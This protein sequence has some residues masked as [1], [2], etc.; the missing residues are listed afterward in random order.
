MKKPLTIEQAVTIEPGD[1]V[2]F[3]DGEGGFNPL[4]VSAVRAKDS[5]NDTVIH[6]R[7]FTPL[8]EFSSSAEI[9]DVIITPVNSQISYSHSRIYAEA[10]KVTPYSVSDILKSRSASQLHSEILNEMVPENGLFNLPIR[11][12]KDWLV[13][14]GNLYSNLDIDLVEE[15]FYRELAREQNNIEMRGSPIVTLDAYYNHKFQEY[16]DRFEQL[17]STY[18]MISYVEKHYPKEHFDNVNH[19]IRTIGDLTK[20]LYN[21]EIDKQTMN[22]L[23]NEGGFSMTPF[24]EAVKM[25]YNDLLSRR[26]PS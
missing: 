17:E 24:K 1:K 6:K 3:R 26:N 21:N 2:Y 9:N 16:Q 12:F 8:I 11:E 20:K 18:R 25:S 10:G 19:P 22:V 7:L 23:I 14:G 5:L 4:I 15:M 13:L